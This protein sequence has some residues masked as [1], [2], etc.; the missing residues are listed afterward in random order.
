MSCSLPGPRGPSLLGC[1]RGLAPLQPTELPVPGP[2]AQHLF[3]SRQQLF[4]RLWQ[5]SRLPGTWT[6][7]EP[8]PEPEP[9]ARTEMWRGAG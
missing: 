6:E 9:E 5:L 3:H 1:R 8:E 7:P 4:E 2:G